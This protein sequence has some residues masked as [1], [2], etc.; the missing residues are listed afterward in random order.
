[1]KKL[2]LTLGFLA[3]TAFGIDHL[4]QSPTG[5]LILDAAPGFSVKVNKSLQCSALSASQALFT[6][7]SKNI[8]SNTTTGSGNVVMSASPT[9]SG[10]IGGTPTFSSAITF[11]TAPVLSSTTAS[12]ALF[13]DASKNVVSNAVTGSGNVVMSASPTLSGTIGGI[14]T[15]SSGSNFKFRTISGS[16]WTL[17]ADDYIL[18]L[19]SSGVQGV[20]LPTNVAGKVLTIKSINT[21]VITISPA[22]GTIDGAANFVLNQWQAVTL[23]CDSTATNWYVLQTGRIGYYE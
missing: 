11:T 22:S 20:T 8:V 18:L 19:S 23:G 10:T 6:D 1:M 5:N 13:T 7:A 16:P 15:F 9:L 3:T 17:N 4:V 14:L 2:L 12:Q 21:G